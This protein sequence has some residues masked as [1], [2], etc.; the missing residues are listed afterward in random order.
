MRE[1]LYSYMHAYVEVPFW[2][3]WKPNLQGGKQTKNQTNHTKT[4]QTKPNQK[5]KQQ[6]PKKGTKTPQQNK[7]QQHKKPKKTTQ[8][9]HTFPK[10][11]KLSGCSILEQ[12]W[13]DKSVMKI[14]PVF[15]FGSFK[16]KLSM[17][18]E[19][20]R[21]ALTCGF[22]IHPLW[23]PADLPGLAW[24]AL[25]ETLGGCWRTLRTLLLPW[26]VNRHM[27]TMPEGKR[28]DIDSF[29]EN[30]LIFQE[31]SYI[32]EKVAWSETCVV[33]I[34]GLAGWF[35]WVRCGLV[36][37]FLNFWKTAKPR[38]PVMFQIRLLKCFISP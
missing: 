35:G 6:Q 20:L 37:I 31:L 34:C 8:N 14:I 30:I 27:K 7:T 17:D 19:G 9:P 26:K 22:W 29:L 1:V 3:T 32:I 12:N 33:S 11:Q 13:S 18:A 36:R 16:M 10:R 5:P 25:L 4:A 15:S 23:D 2:N 28:A 24:T 21:W 38:K